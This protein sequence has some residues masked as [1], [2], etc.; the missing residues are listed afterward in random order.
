MLG[1]SISII[2]KQPPIIL[3]R[4]WQRQR[5]SLYMI[6]IEA[7][8]NYQNSQGKSQRN[9]TASPLWDKY[10]FKGRH[11]LFQNVYIWKFSK[12]CSK[13]VVIIIL[14]NLIGH[15]H[16]AFCLAYMPHDEE[17]PPGKITEQKQHKG[18]RKLLTSLT[19]TFTAHNPL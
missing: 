17:E 5:Y 10:H 15:R 9:R 7:I 11:L 12:Y 16:L 14:K 1:A 8:Y 19:T 18:M 3:G 4:F 13:D 2:L 6:G